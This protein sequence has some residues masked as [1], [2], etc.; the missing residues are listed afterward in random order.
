MNFSIQNISNTDFD[1]TKLL[2]VSETFTKMGLAAAKLDSSYT[3]S[4]LFAPELKPIEASS[5]SEDCEDAESDVDSEDSSISTDSPRSLYPQEILP[6]EQQ[7]LQCSTALQSLG[8]EKKYAH[9]TVRQAVLQEFI[10]CLK[11]EINPDHEK[12]N[13]YLNAICK[14][15]NPKLKQSMPDL[16]PLPN[17]LPIEI[18]LKQAAFLDVCI[19][20]VMYPGSEKQKPDL[21]ISVGLLK[22]CE[23]LFMCHAKKLMANLKELHDHVTKNL[24]TQRGM[25]VR[26][27]K[28]SAKILDPKHV[29]FKG[30]EFFL[31]GILKLK[32]FPTSIL[33]KCEAIVEELHIYQTLTTMDTDQQ[34]L[35][36]NVLI[37]KLNRIGGSI[38]SRITSLKE[39]VTQWQQK[40]SE[41]SSALSLL[42]G[43]QALGLQ[44]LVLPDEVGKNLNFN[45]ITKKINNVEFE[46]LSSDAGSLES[47]CQNLKQ[48]LKEFQ[49]STEL[50]LNSVKA[51]LQRMNGLCLIQ[52]QSH[53]TYEPISSIDLM[54][55]EPKKTPRNVQPKKQASKKDTKNKQSKKNV[56]GKNKNSS[57][58]ENKVSVAES[59]PK[60]DLSKIIDKK[61]VHE[62][63]VRMSALADEYRRSL[64]RHL[65]SHDITKKLNLDPSVKDDIHTAMTELRHHI[66]HSSNGME[67]LIQAVHEEN[68]TQMGEIIPMLILDWGVQL[69]QTM[70]IPYLAKFKNFPFNHHLTKR[71]RS[72]GI[73]NELSKEALEHLQAMDLAVVWGRY[74]LS[75][76]MGFIKHQTKIPLA[77]QMIK[78][79]YRI[80]DKGR[81]PKF[82]PSKEAEYLLKQVF[83]LHRKQIQTL[84]ELVS[85]STKQNL[86][87]DDLAAQGRLLDLWNKIEN[88]VL[89]SIKT[90]EAKKVDL[91]TSQDPRLN[92]LE[93]MILDIDKCL[94]AKKI[95][96]YV[97]GENPY[98]PLRDAKAHLQRLYFTMKLCEKNKNPRYAAL[99]FRNY[100]KIQQIFEQ[101]YMSRAM[102]E[103][104]GTIVT[105][106]LKIYHET[107]ND[108]DE[109]QASQ[110]TFGKNMHYSSSEDTSKK[111]CPVNLLKNLEQMTKRYLGVE[112]GFTKPNEKGKGSVIDVNYEDTK[113][114]LLTYAIPLMKVHVEKCLASIKRMNAEIK[115]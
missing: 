97:A 37:Q 83:Q 111:Q 91:Q 33:T 107:L 71:S 49:L 78:E 100:L 77:L 7:I 108:P 85:A 48:D 61:E 82:N 75:A 68:W 21:R 31:P 94:K 86:N 17:G 58:N 5:S 8:W 10:Q 64:S 115:D 18:L 28:G 95:K 65:K 40:N 104:Y 35:K 39:T 14:V 13:F 54:D 44:S 93:M 43:M 67:V 15:L 81:D 50:L 73:D 3:F 29:K 22:E 55:V 57:T 30:E 45:S 42:S 34:A 46:F 96:G 90:K 38:K 11:T 102:A 62:D 87:A 6:L 105:H 23:V 26:A 70:T 112:D 24:N 76:E 63:F 36:M 72:I 9:L 101:L 56:K 92:E 110:F 89:E 88:K 4:T 27:S 103:G 66:I 25:A 59:K 12:N 80:M 98:A 51:H 52:G 2:Q 99:I 84:G 109:M 16:K 114:Y 106:D 1:F 60:S 79:S 20:D 32:I 19:S 47:R 113:D 69:E 74:P 41:F 53:S